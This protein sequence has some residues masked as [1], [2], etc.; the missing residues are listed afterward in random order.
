MPSLLQSMLHGL[1]L[2]YQPAV[3]RPA[4]QPAVLKS[5]L[6]VAL[7]QLAVLKSLLQH[8]VLALHR[9]VLKFRLAILAQLLLAATESVVSDSRST[10]DC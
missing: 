5:L 9:A 1:L 3:L 7:A 10:A 8:A 6:V 4:D 2:T